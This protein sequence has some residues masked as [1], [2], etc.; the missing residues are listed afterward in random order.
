[1]PPLKPSVPWLTSGLPTIHSESLHERSCQSSP[2][3]STNQ[4]G[5]CDK[6]VCWP[7]RLKIVTALTVWLQEIVTTACSAV[8]DVLLTNL[9][10]HCPTARSAR[11]RLAHAL[12]LW[13]A[14]PP[15]R[16]V[17]RLLLNSSA[18]SVKQGWGS[19]GGH[20]AYRIPLIR[21]SHLDVSLDARGRCEAAPQDM[22]RIGSVRHSLVPVGLEPAAWPVAFEAAERAF[23]LRWLRC[24]TGG[25]KLRRNDGY[26]ANPIRSVESRWVEYGGQLWRRRAR[27]CPCVVARPAPFPFGSRFS[28]GRHGFAARTGRVHHSRS[29][30]LTVCLVS[31]ALCRIAK[32]NASDAALAEAAMGSPPSAWSWK[33]LCSVQSASRARVFLRCGRDWRNLDKRRWRRSG[34]GIGIAVQCVDPWQMGPPPDLRRSGHEQCTGCD[35]STCGVPAIRIFLGYPALSFHRRSLQCPHCRTHARRHW[36]RRP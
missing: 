24:R 3:T 13:C 10:H 17:R 11:S 35:C 29:S 22:A 18:I 6:R 8:D 34:N 15:L 1:M 26:D 25:S 12:D 21:P 33:H 27:R 36:P 14:R 2:R 9:R 28:H 30:A 32:R 5:T 31:R 4:E 23:V 7:G 19:G 16:Y 20:R